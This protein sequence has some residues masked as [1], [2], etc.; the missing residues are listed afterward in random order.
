MFGLCRIRSWLVLR[1]FVLACTTRCSIVL[2]RLAR[3]RAI[4]SCLVFGRFRLGRSVR[5]RSP[6]RRHYVLAGKFARLGRCRDSRTQ[7]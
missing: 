4:R 5:R 7:A 2:F 3:R 1:R 6:V